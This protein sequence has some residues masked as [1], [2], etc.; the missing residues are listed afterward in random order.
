VRDILLTFTYNNSVPFPFSEAVNASGALATDGT[1]FIAPLVNDYNFGPM[2]S[3]LNYTG[4]TPNG[5]IENPNNSQFLEGLRRAFSY[6]GEIL[7][8]AWNDD[9]AILGIRA[10]KLVGQG[11][12]R[13]NYPELDAVVYVG[14]GNNPTA[15]SFYHADDAVGLIRNTVGIY[16]ILPDAR[17]QVIRGLDLAAVVDPDGASRDLGSLQLDAFQ[18]HDF[19]LDTR[20]PALAGATVHFAFSTNSSQTNAQRLLTRNGSIVTDGINGTP[21]VSTETRMTNISFDLFIRY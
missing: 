13:A 3:L 2:Q 5:I 19:E 18:G 20:T 21:R 17:G 9:P 4:Q 15:T 1:E 14:D 12:L 11:I 7:A 8:A 10:L 16:L 6:P